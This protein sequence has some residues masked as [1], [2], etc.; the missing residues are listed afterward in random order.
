[1]RASAVRSRLGRGDA[2]PAAE[3]AAAESAAAESAAAE[4]AAEPTTEPTAFKQVW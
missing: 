4:S 1:L 3:S 2:E